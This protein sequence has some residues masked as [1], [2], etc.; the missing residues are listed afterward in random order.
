V[1]LKPPLAWNTLILWLAPIALVLAAA[2]VAARNAIAARAARGVG[3]ASSQALSA[4][5]EAKL[6]A[7][8]G[9][10]QDEASGSKT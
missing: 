5:E 3:V 2:G 4:D 6:K 9:N 10:A 7:V 1:L 8:L